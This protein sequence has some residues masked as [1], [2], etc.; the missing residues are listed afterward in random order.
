MAD[1]KWLAKGLKG[2]CAGDVDLWGHEKNPTLQDKLHKFRE[3]H[4]VLSNQIK[5]LPNASVLQ[6]YTNLK[7]TLK[8]TIT[9]MRDVRE[10]ENTERKRLLNYEKLNPDPNYKAAAKGAC[11]SHIYDCIIFITNALELNKNICRCMSFL[12]KNECSF[13]SIHVSLQSQPNVR[14]LLSPQYVS[15]N[16][17]LDAHPEWFKQQSQQWKKLRSAAHVT[18]ST[19]YSALGFRGFS[20]VKNHFREFVYKK[21]PVPVDAVTQVRMQHCIQ[22]EVGVLSD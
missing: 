21:G 15:Q 12:Q 11:R 5:S 6:C 18:A 22:H 17:T 14:R 16:T 4:N 19:A 9:K 20:Q 1:C 10:I 13:N 3:D 7:Y 2:D 8:L